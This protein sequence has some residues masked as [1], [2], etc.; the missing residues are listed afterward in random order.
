MGH[1]QDLSPGKRRAIVYAGTGSN[2]ESCR[3]I[4]NKVGCGKTTVAS[5]LK[6]F[7]EEG[8]V[9]VKKRTGRPPKI[10]SPAQARLKRLVKQDNRRLCLAKITSVWTVREQP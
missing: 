2:K 6:Q 4:A 8:S 10:G 7:R 9:N 5:I 1:K 3:A